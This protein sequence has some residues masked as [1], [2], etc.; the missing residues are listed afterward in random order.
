[1]RTVIGIF[2]AICGAVLFLLI[3]SGGA[4]FHWKYVQA[5]LVGGA[6]PALGGWLLGL[7]TQKLYSTWKSRKNPN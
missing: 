2:A 5:G 7:F 1:M 6:L 3:T 4:F